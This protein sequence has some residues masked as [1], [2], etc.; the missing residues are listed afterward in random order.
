RARALGK[1]DAKRGT[2]ALTAL[3]AAA[4]DDRM[5]AFMLATAQLTGGDRTAIERLKTI[6]ETDATYRVPVCIRLVRY[7]RE[8]G[9]S[10]GADQWE[11]QLETSGAELPQAHNA[12]A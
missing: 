7:L 2:A 5:T 12:P 8:Q 9:E 4:P 10:I 6:A 11:T 3:A 1:L